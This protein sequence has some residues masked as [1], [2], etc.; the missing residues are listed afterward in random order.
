MNEKADIVLGVAF[1]VFLV[2]TLGGGCSTTPAVD[3][4]DIFQSGVAI[5]KLETSVDRNGENFRRLQE[6]FD[7]ITRRAAEIGDSID[8]LVFTSTELDRLLREF[9]KE[10]G[11]VGVDVLESNENTHSAG[12]PGDS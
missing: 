12:G 4:G 2:F 11:E 1:I 6:G 9:F 10:S 3:T 5:G 7:D 8:K